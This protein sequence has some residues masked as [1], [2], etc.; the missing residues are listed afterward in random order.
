MRD[1]NSAYNLLCTIE[2]FTKISGLTINRTKSECIILKYES[3]I[4]TYNDK[5]LDIPVVENVKVLG[6]YFGTNKIIC[7]YQNFYCKLP[8]IEKLINIWKQ[9]NLTLFGKNVLINSFL[10]SQILYNGQIEFPPPEFLKSFEILK[11][12]FLWNGGTPKIAHNALIGSVQQGG[13][14]YVDIREKFKAL[15]IKL[16]RLSAGL[17]PKHAE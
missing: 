3:Q 7:N 9:R 4:S 1:E 17:N 14:A 10:N 2:A 16:L 8:K 6:H 12:D 15:N 11:K 5:F 13:I